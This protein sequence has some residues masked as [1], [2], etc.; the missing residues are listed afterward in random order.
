MADAVWVPQWPLPSEKLKAAKELV[1]E[2]LDLGHV[3][4]TQSPWNTPI[5]VVKKKSGK[6]R[7]LHDLRAIN[8]QMQ[9]WVLY[10]EDSPYFQLYL[11]IGEL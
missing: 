7:L 9:L 3:E 6:W 2:R 8:A 5:V 10:K 4:P 1:Q 11:R